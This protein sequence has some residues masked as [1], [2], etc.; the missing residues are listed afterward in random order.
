MFPPKQAKNPMKN[1]L[2]KYAL[3]SMAFTACVFDEK[4]ANRGTIVGNELRVGTL[5][6]ADGG[7]AVNARVRVFEVGHVPDSSQPA[8]STRTNAQGRFKIDPLAKGEYNII[9]ELDG[10]VSYQDSV[11]ISETAPGFGSDTLGTP[12]S[13]AGFVALQPHHD[14]RTATVQV[15]GTNSFANVDASGRFRLTS[16]GAGRYTMRAVTTM[17]EYTPFY[18]TVL[19][20]SGV[21]VT[22]RDT[23]RIPYTGIPVILGLKAAYDTLTGRALI[24]W[25]PVS[26]SA[27][28]D[29]LVFRSG[30][31]DL[32]PSEDPIG[33]TKGGEYT[34][35]LFKTPYF[36]GSNPAMDTLP[37]R[38]EYRVKARSLSGKIGPYFGS[39]E[40]DAPSPTMVRTFVRF[41]SASNPVSIGDT[42]SIPVRFEN[43]TRD[44]ASLVW[45]RNGIA[46]RNRAV[47][48]RTGSDT[49]VFIANELGIQR[50]EVE[51]LD[52]GGAIWS[53]SM[54]LS[55]TAEPPKPFAGNDTV[56]LLDEPLH[57]RD[58]GKPGR[59]KIVSWKWK[60]AGDSF[61]TPVTQGD[62]IVSVIRRGPEMYTLR[63]TDEY[64]Q[65]AESSR[66]VRVSQPME[67]WRATS[68][69][70]PYIQGRDVKRTTL[71]F[72]G[73]TWMFLS[74]WN[75]TGVKPV[76]IWNSG[77]IK[78]WT[79]VNDSAAFP[80]RIVRSAVAY[81]GRIWIMGGEKEMGGASGYNDVWSS[82]D[83]IGWTLVSPASPI[84]TENKGDHLFIL[85]SQMAL[86]THDGRVLRSPDGLS[87]SL[88]GLSPLG[89]G[90]V[91][92]A[93]DFNGV[94]TLA[95][96]DGIRLYTNKDNSWSTKAGLIE[97]RWYN[98]L[99][100]E[101]RLSFND[102]Y[103]VFGDAFPYRFP[104]KWTSALGGL[105]PSCFEAM[106]GAAWLMQGGRFR[107]EP[108]ETDVYYSRGLP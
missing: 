35:T 18:F 71:A 87:W 22:L 25:D 36:P 65:T 47:G 4:E 64:G 86:L 40:I 8:F 59:G 11:F 3:L 61:F 20:E 105:Y 84:D 7:P 76:Q 52:A 75:E 51:V 28:S 9:G 23:I 108:R 31:S 66:Y 62:T 44:N 56:M 89:G 104:G 78:D 42:V 39:V 58:L 81:G 29:Y 70:L 15:M 55:V 60:L 49:L 88:W 82:E 91:L 77:N 57:L 63:V 99:I 101:G 17:E 32:I 38:F 54:A 13:V 24:T 72:K 73:K 1:Q 90:E 67:L 45:R 103:Q 95:G 19:V 53:G 50:F 14:T 85:N 21:P 94:L 93:V 83:G 80:V 100:M 46:V 33:K 10:T 37:Y 12:G 26:Y 16:L 41:P 98:L 30:S 74:S 107:N 6:L 102:G 34:D 68:I 27:L 79:R 96:K 2:M 106:D 48:G 43:R 69:E 5:Y 92:S 97:G